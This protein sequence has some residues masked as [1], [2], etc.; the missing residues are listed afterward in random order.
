VTGWARRPTC[1]P[2]ACLALGTATPA[3]AAYVAQANVWWGWLH[4]ETADPRPPAL[5]ERTSTQIAKF[6]CVIE[7]VIANFK[8]W[9]I[10]HT[11][12][13]RPL[14]TFTETISAMVALHFYALA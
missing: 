3:D 1:A 5:G 9:R 4:Q 6:R 7:Q 2:L 14:E 8:A 12:Y 10:M 13:R 11:D